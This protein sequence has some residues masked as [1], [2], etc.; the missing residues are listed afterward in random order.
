MIDERTPTAEQRHR[1][2]VL[3]RDQGLCALR[4]LGSC[5]GRLQF[6]HPIPRQRIK[7]EHGLANS[8]VGRSGSPLRG[9]DLDDLIADPRNGVVICETHHSGH[10]DELSAD[11]LPEGIWVFAAEYGLEWS[12]DRDFAWKPEAA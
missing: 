1:A 5:Y 4:R 9:A 8:P 6:H 11:D 10:E 2:A 3:E 12:L 7:H